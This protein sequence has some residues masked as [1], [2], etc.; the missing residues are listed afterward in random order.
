[1]KTTDWLPRAAIELEN[2]SKLGH[3]QGPPSHQ[4]T[5]GLRFIISMWPVPRLP[6]MKWFLADP[7]QLDHCK[8]YNQ[9][10]QK[11]ILECAVGG[12]V[13]WDITMEKTPFHADEHPPRN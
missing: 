8:V 11:A 4:G 13:P 1:M 10:Q 2:M 6:L 7:S 3:V 12:L 9:L 5:G